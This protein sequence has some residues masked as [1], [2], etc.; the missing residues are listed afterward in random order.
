MA[1]RFRI[2]VL[3]QQH[4]RAR[5]L[6]RH[7]AA[8]RCWSPTN[9][10]EA[11]A[12]ARGGRARTRASSRWQVTLER[13]AVTADAVLGRQAA[14]RRSPGAATASAMMRSCWRPRP[15][16]APGER[17]V[18]LG[19]GVGAAG[20]GAGRARRG[21]DG[22]AGRDRSRAGGAWRR[23]MLQ[24]NG[25]AGAGAAWSCS[26][27]RRRRARSRPPGLRPESVD[28]RADE[29]A[30]QRSGAATDVARS[31]ARGWPTSPPPRHTGALG[32]SAAHGCCARAAR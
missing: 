31:P 3:D 20:L 19:A 5:R 4:E 26:M 32:P 2:V 7:S 15:R 13:L 17:A 25:L 30:V 11:R 1:P 24:R 16:R 27:W 12:A 28:A 9:T 10:A 18:D 21:A 8:P 6:D 23:K 29:S 22:D 14:A